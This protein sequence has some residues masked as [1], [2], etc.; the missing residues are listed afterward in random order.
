MQFVVSDRHTLLYISTFTFQLRQQETALV[1]LYTTQFVQCMA[2]TIGK[3][4]N[5]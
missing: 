2:L 5:S 1:D 3:L 4:T